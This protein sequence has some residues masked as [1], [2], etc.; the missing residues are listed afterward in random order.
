MP[1]AIRRVGSQ[2]M[3]QSL[4]PLPDYGMGWVCSRLAVVGAYPP[5]DALGTAA[6]AH[7]LFGHSLMATPKPPQPASI[8][9]GPPAG[10][11]SKAKKRHA[12]FQIL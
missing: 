3:L 2:Y 4:P 8:L 6:A 5:Q 9:P 10:K 1:A 7:S 11:K 12:T